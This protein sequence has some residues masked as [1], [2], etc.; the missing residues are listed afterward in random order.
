MLDADPTIWECGFGNRYGTG[1]TGTC[2]GTTYRRC[3]TDFDCPNGL[4]CLGYAPQWCG[5]ESPGI[6]STGSDGSA[7][8]CVSAACTLTGENVCVRC[9]NGRID[10]LQEECEDGNFVSGDGCS[11]HCQFEGECRGTG[12]PLFDPVEC[13]TDDDCAVL[14]N[15]AE[16]GPSAP[17]T[18]VI[19]T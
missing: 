2:D 18:C 11:D 19:G 6:C 5:A 7:P 8:A 1:E 13:A 15:C 10:G 17:C 12:L 4:S 3:T 16:D 14:A 9:G